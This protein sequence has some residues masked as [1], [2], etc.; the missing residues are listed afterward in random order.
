MLTSINEK[1]SP[2][3]PLLKRSKYNRKNKEAMKGEAP[4]ISKR[5]Q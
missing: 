5:A 3:A 2:P 1:G 4:I